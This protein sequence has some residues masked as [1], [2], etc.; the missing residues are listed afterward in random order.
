MK[1]KIALMF[2]LISALL[3][4]SLIN[5]KIKIKDSGIKT[6]HKVY[7]KRYNKIKSSEILD[8][9][10]KY[11][12]LKLEEIKYDNNNMYVDVS[13]NGD[14]KNINNI[15]NNFRQ[16]KAAAG[17]EEINFNKTSGHDESEMKL[18]FKPYEEVK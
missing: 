16:E 9:I 18:L 11:K 5:N 8:I 4:I 17:I 13:A 3:C 14:V 6:S 2:V 12:G 10:E 7:I 15:V 1:I